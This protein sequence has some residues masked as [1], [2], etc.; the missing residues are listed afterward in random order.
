M[1]SSGPSFEES[2][3]LGVIRTS[4]SGVRALTFPEVP[5]RSPEASKRRPTTDTFYPKPACRI[6][7]PHTRL[8]P[9]TSPERRIP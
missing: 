7:P 3:P 6:A 8:T 4:P 5:V 1:T 2:R 9:A